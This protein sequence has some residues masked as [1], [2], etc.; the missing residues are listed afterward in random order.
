[1][2]SMAFSDVKKFLPSWRG[3]LLLLGGL[4]VLVSCCLSLYCARSAVDRLNTSMDKT[5][6]RSQIL[7]DEYRRTSRPVLD[8]AAAWGS[9]MDNVIWVGVRTMSELAEEGH[10]HRTVYQS[11]CATGR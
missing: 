2:L 4:G 6:T 11:N 7:T 5:P 1:M 3:G 8:F 10:S 9:C